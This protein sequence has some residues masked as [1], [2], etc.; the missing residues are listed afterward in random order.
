MGGALLA[1][2]IHSK[3]YEK[4]ISRVTIGASY[5]TF[6]LFQLLTL[7]YFY[8]IIDVAIWQISIYLL[9]SILIYIITGIILKKGEVIRVYAK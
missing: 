6:A 3:E 5:A 1:S 7:L 2:I 4:N 8:Q 9:V